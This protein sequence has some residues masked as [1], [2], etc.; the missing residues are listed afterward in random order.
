MLGG[1][2]G[3]RFDPTDD[4]I[5]P[6]WQNP[7]FPVTPDFARPAGGVRARGSGIVVA[8]VPGCAD[9]TYG[10]GGGGGA[11]GDSFA[12][13]SVADPA[14]TSS[15]PARARSS[16]TGRSTSRRSPPPAAASRRRRSAP[17][18]QACCRPA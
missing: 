12:D 11:G 7:D 9:L 1:G 17:A 18:T 5:D 8:A 4:R 2:A 13:P 14:F 10:F 16:W 15:P 3:I 6:S